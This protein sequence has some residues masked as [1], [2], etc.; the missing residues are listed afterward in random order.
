MA[1]IFVADRSVD[2]PT[3]AATRAPM[4]DRGSKVT[5]SVLKNLDKWMRVENFGGIVEG[6]NLLPMKTFSRS[7]CRW[8]SVRGAATN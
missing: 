6:T 7:A 1:F 4:T 5:V 2:D 3:V 8:C